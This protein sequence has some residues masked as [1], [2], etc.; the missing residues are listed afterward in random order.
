VKTASQSSPD[1][2]SAP[3]SQR[4]RLGGAV[5]RGV[6]PMQQC[7]SIGDAIVSRNG[8]FFAL[9]EA[10]GRLRVYCGDGEHPAPLWESARSGSGGRFFALV[11]SD[12]NFCI[13]LGSGL[14][15]N[16][17]WLWGTQITAEN[18]PFHAVLQDDG[19][20]CVRCG[21]GAAAEPAGDVVWRSGVTDPVAVI[22]TI[23][24]IDYELASAQI[25]QSRPSDLYR[26]TVTNP[27]AQIQTSMISGSVTVSDTTGWSD[28]LLTEAPTPFGFRHAVPVFQGGSIMLTTDASHAYI[29]NGAATTAKTWGFNAPAAVPPR[30]SMTCLVSATRSS[31]RVPYRISGSFT[32]ASGRK[33]RGSVTGMYTGSNCHDLNVA[34]T[35][36]D[37]APAG[38]CTINRPLTPMPTIVGM[39]VPHPIEASCFYQ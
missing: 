10:D 3:P 2:G 38:N 24:A 8:M 33:V 29:R 23:D 17:G 4:Q 27:N 14:S 1:T 21:T 31:I 13:Y 34:L 28:D 26:E 12:A 15:S 11:Q 7:L 35:T 19:E 6:L 16:Q 20:L 18:G 32:L 36:F 39:A 37:P 22:D 25:V 30:S 9:L 5:F